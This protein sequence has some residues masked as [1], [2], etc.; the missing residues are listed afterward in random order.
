M[1]KIMLV[2]KS[3]ITMGNAPQS[4][5][6]AKW[7]PFVLKLCPQSKKRQLA[8]WILGSSPHYFYK[9]LDQNYYNLSHLEFLEAEHLRCMASRERIYEEVLRPFI[10]QNCVI[11][12]YG[13]GPGYLAKA[14]SKC[15]TSVFALDISEGVIEC[16]KIMNFSEKIHYITPVDFES[17]VADSSIDFIYSIAVIQHMTNDV[18]KEMLNQCFRKLKPGGMILLHVQL[19]DDRWKSE[20]KWRSM[21]I[22]LLVKLNSS[23]V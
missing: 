9:K 21:T 11:L 19:E 4:F 15:A 5:L 1:E 22:Q 18:F 16:A 23:M 14:A 3:F 12:D 20:E 10:R 13:C 8:L 17:I 7:I 6:G 2:I